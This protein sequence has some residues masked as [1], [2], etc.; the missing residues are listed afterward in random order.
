MLVKDMQFNGIDVEGSENW[1]E[2]VGKFA[3]LLA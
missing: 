1:G 2:W 3:Y